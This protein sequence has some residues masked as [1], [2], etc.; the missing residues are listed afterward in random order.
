MRSGY[1]LSTIGNNQQVKSSTD[2]LQVKEI[3]EKKVK[4]FFWCCSCG[5]SSEAGGAGGRCPKH[6][7]YVFNL[8][9]SIIQGRPIDS[10]SVT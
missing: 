2:N 6:F 5:G 1:P 9:P 7:V 10:L 3:Y 4:F 8:R